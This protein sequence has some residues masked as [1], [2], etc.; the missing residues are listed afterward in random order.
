MIVTGSYSLL[1]SSLPRVVPP[2]PQHCG[3]HPLSGVRQNKV[4]VTQTVFGSLRSGIG[5]LFCEGL[6]F[7][8]L[9][10]GQGHRMCLRGGA[11]AAIIADATPAYS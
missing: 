4:S 3:S 1:H 6:E 5:Q 10:Y 8:E 11:K 7:C 2:V 9:I